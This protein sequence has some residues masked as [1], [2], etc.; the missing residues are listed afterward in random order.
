MFDETHKPLFTY[1][2]EKGLDVGV[3]NEVHLLGRDSNAERVQR[4]VLSTPRPKP[5]T[6]PE[7]ILLI[8]AVQHLGGRPLD[9][10]VFQGGH[11]KWALSSV[12]LGYVRSARR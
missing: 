2:V 5:I 3:K 8:N 4:I 9:D 1:F 11:C 10:F 12:G 6:E 7:E